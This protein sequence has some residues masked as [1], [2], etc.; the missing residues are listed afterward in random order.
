[1]KRERALLDEIIFPGGKPKAC[2]M[3]YD[4]GTIHDRRLVATMNRY[5]VRATFN[6]NSGFLGQPSVTNGPHGSIDTGEI[7][8]E[9]VTTLYTGHEIAGHGLYHASPTHVGSSAFLYETIADKA[10]LETLTGTLVRGYAYPFGLY[11]ETAKSVLRLAGYHYARVV[12]STR[13]FDLPTDF[14]AWEPTCHHADAKLME[15]AELFCKADAFP[16]RTKLFYVWGH[17]YEFA[18]DDN[19]DCMETLCA[20]LQQHGEDVWFAT[21]IE[22]FDYVTAFRQ[23]EYGA[24]GGLVYNPTALE[25]HLRRGGTTHTIPPLTTLHLDS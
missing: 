25:L 22:V 4:D 9:E 15:L 17:S 10:A 14:L 23:L 21:N 13:R 11:D 19:W 16:M 6:L 20:Y 2:T 5:G 1:M 24:E 8:P 18:G 12:D 7:A 3:S